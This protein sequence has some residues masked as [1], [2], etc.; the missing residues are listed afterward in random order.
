[1]SDSI[2]E[3]NLYV[4][5]Q[6]RGLTYGMASNEPLAY[7]RHKC[8]III[9]DPQYTVLSKDTIHYTTPDYW[10]RQLQYMLYLDGVKVHQSR[11]RCRK[12]AR[13]KKDLEELGYTVDRIRY[14][15]PT[16]K[17]I[18]EIAN[19][20]EKRLLELGYHKRVN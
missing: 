6:N 4:E 20:V 11:Y 8:V 18:R 9:P 16:V 2:G 13:I 3:S 15:K 12:D 19:Q 14:K 17:K 5:L 10:W 1:M 7:I